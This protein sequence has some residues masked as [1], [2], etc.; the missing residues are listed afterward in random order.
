MSKFAERLQEQLDD[1]KMTAE[2]LGTELSISS[3]N[4]YKWLRDESIP[5]LDSL[6]KLSDYFKCNLDFLSGRAVE[7]YYTAKNVM[8]ICNRLRFIISE[9]DTS[10]YMFAKNAKIPRTSLHH[11][12]TGR[13]EPLLDSLIKIADYLDCTLDWLIGRE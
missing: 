13:S 2:Q 8:P 1:H 12:L 4:I 10:D 7:N 11:W 9:K 5:N 3:S 6:I